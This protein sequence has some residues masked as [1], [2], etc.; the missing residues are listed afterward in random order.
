MK[1][2]ISNKDENWKIV[3]NRVCIRALLIFFRCIVDANA[4]LY[5][6]YDRYDDSCYG[7]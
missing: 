2:M 7:I 3:R 4:C 5:G 1:N 6:L